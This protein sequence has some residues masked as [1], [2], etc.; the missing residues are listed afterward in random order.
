MNEND[1]IFSKSKELQF[2]GIKNFPI[3][4]ANLKSSSIFKVPEKQLILGKEFFGTYE[5][6]TP[7][8]ELVLMF[9]N[10]YEA[11]YIVYSSRNRKTDI[12]IPLKDEKIKNAVME[13]EKYL[14][15]LLLDIKRDYS[16][17]FSTGKNFTSVSNEIF[18][19]LNLIRL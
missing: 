19:K 9:N 16:K 12:K 3:D 5:V 1:F 10:E 14:D 4:F 2:S 17:R 13:Y 6:T 18:K 8:G 11:K 15:L 7:T